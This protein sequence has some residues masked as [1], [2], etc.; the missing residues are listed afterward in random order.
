MSEQRWQSIFVLFER[1]LDVEASQRSRLLDE[2]CGGDTELR[3]GVEG[4]LEAH[5]QASLFFD[6]S[7]PAQR[8]ELRRRGESLADQAA[9]AGRETPFM[10]QRV[11]ELPG[12]S[13]EAASDLPFQTV[14]PYR[15]LRQIGQGGMSTVYLA[16]RDDDAYRRRVV[17]KVV[18][19]DMQSRAMLSRLRAERQILASLEHPNIA[20]LYDGGSTAQGIPYFIMEHV[21]GIPIDRYCTQHQLSVEERLALFCKVCV[22]VQYAHQNLVVHRD[23]KPSNI[24]VTADGEPKLLDFGIAKLL[25]PG[26]AGSDIEP[27]AAWQRLMTPSFASPEQIRGELVTT[28][29]DVYSLGV[30]LYVLL[31]GRLPH[32]FEG[33]S[34]REI[35]RLLTET[36][37]LAPSRVAT[38]AITLDQDSD[39]GSNEARSAGEAEQDALLSRSRRVLAGDVDAIVLKALRTSPS[40]RYASVGRFA[41]DVDRFLSGLPVEA[42]GGT[43]RYRAGKFA[44]R[45]RTA[46]VSSSVAAVLLISA[47]VALALQNRRVV[48]ERDKKSQVVSL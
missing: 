12:E 5:D 14:G 36:E 46:V 33:R 7:E 16:V 9:A 42:R 44:R 22:A 45:H 4:M 26:M 17:V 38:D 30:L 43:W 32:T 10:P 40:R 13:G 28:V 41:A 8:S 11:A 23:I 20:R 34:L 1:A 29:S 47:A 2:A 18:R 31:T 48:G 3:R 15:V 21:E 25:N 37:P 35:E 6:R 27:T 24:L 39:T 19:R